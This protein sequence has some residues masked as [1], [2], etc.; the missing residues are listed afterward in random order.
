MTSLSPQECVLKN[1]KTVIL[2]EAQTDDAPALLQCLKTY[3]A[4]S[5]YIPKYPEEITLTEAQE[6]NWI[7]SFLDRDNSVLLVAV[8][9][10]EIIGNIDI[11]G[12]TRKMM[13]HT[14][15]IGMGMLE[16]WCNTGLGTHLMRKAIDWAQ[17][18]QQLELLWLQVYDANTLGR[19]LYK[20][21]DFVE[22]GTLPHFFKKGAQYFDNITMY[23]EVKG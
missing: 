14:G 6:S 10:E 3:I 15:V 19:A 9:D 22:C 11:T 7:Q 12:G 2:R 18:N 17:E 21:M 8:H 4:Q 23:L 1:G 16:D 5:D 13:A 20:K